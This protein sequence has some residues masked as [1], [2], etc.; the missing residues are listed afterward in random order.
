MASRAAQYSREV[1][2][3]LIEILLWCHQ[4]EP[5]KTLEEMLRWF[6]EYA[7]DGVIPRTEE[8]KHPT[9]VSSAHG[10]ISCI[11][12][13]IDTSREAGHSV[14]QVVEM[15]EGSLTLLQKMM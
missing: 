13:M 3:D 12:K 2:K 15:M 8:E 5:F 4:E 7:G 6:L 14:Q 11:C 1:R 10:S 9:M